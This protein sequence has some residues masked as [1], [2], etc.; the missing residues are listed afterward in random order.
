ME[1][2]KIDRLKC[3]IL[4]GQKLIKMPKMIYFDELKI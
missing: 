3:D 1:N 4:S 2:A